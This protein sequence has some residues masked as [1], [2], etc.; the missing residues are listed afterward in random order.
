MADS[1]LNQQIFQV[2]K[3]GQLGMQ[4][5]Q[6][7]EAKR[8]AKQAKLQ[9]DVEKTGADQAYMKS[10]NTL[11]GDWKGV[12]E[13]QYSTFKEA[14]INYEQ[15]QSA[16]AK[17]EMEYQASLLNHALQAGTTILTTAG[18]NYTTAKGNN[19]DGYAV[20]AEEAGTAY[21]N[22]VN[23]NIE[24]KQTPQGVMIKE[25]ENWIPFQ[26]SSY[27][28]SELTENNTF[29]VPKNI[30]LGEYANTTKF[31]DKW[32]GIISKAGSEQ[33]AVNR[34]LKE[35]DIMLEKNEDF[36]KDVH[37]YH[38]INN[39][40]IGEYD[41]FGSDDLRQI[42]MT[43]DDEQVNEDAVNSYR[44]GVVADVKARWFADDSDGGDGSGIKSTYDVRVIPDVNISADRIKVNGQFIEPSV[45]GNVPS[46]KFDYFTTLPSGV[47][48]KAEAE[49]KDLPKGANAYQV[50]GIG[51]VDGMPYAKKNTY[52]AQDLAT[53][54]DND[55]KGLDAKEVI[56]EPLTREEFTGMKKDAQDAIIV[57]FEEA[58]Y[59]LN[60]WLT[61]NKGENSV[62]SQEQT[63]GEQNPLVAELK[64]QGFSDEEIQ[65]ILAD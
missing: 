49:A 23:S 51:F 36:F 55:F 4:L 62:P 17:R 52:A 43:L 13:A 2:P 35:F 20:S 14:A 18:E 64:S 29:L 3:L 16:T 31:V 42:E 21:K 61:G 54:M 24:F 57:R 45:E 7:N 48:P 22:F 63:E 38:G 26:N 9:K 32:N 28:S 65:E 37:I 8:K 44:E 19:F 30:K 15:T 33:D 46:V 47:R 50:V 58:G 11:T 39:R 34:V 40:S 10:I 27:F 41:R 53:A 1:P 5:D 6:A 25:G 12:A 60:S 56:V 59:D